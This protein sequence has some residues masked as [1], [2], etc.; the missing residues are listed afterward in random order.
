MVDLV[1]DAK[2]FF[3]EKIRRVCGREESTRTRGSWSSSTCR[4]S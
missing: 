3:Q 1:G 4:T 2:P